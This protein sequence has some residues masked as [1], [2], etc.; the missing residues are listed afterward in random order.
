MTRLDSVA[1][2]ASAGSGKTYV[3]TSRFLALL[4]AG[5]APDRILAVT[6]TRAAAREILERL[7]QRLGEACAGAHHAFWPDDVSIID[8]DVV[9]PA[10]IHGPRPLTDLYLLALALGIVTIPL[11]FFTLIAVSL[12]TGGQRQSTPA[13]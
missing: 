2:L 8:R 12:L 10:R 6:F 9:D 1:I 5:V 4:L 13:P 3:L 11:G 7:F